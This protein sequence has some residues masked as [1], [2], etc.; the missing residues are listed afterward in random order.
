VNSGSITAAVASLV[1]FVFGH[2]SHEAKKPIGGES[3][4]AREFVSAIIPNL[5]VFNLKTF[6]SYGITISTNE[7]LLSLA[8]ALICVS[9]FLIAAILTF[10][11]K[12][13]LT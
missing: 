5:E 8:Y 7:L 12:D 6:A 1:F 13:I 11:R 3:L 9:I 2:Y 10:D 4:L